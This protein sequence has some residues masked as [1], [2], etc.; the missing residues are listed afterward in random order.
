MTTFE[1]KK[2]LSEQFP[3]E[4]QVLV[5]FEN[6]KDPNEPPYKMVY[7]YNYSYIINNNIGNSK[8]NNNK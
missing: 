4:T 1:D 3:P 5:E 8:K 2:K 7:N 6:I